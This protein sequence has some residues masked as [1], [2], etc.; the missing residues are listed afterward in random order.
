MI[1]L[2]MI[3][4]SI[5]QCPIQW[6]WSHSILLCTTISPPVPTHKNFSHQPWRWTMPVNEFLPQYPDKGWITVTVL[7]EEQMFST[8]PSIFWSKCNQTLESQWL[9]RLLVRWPLHSHQGHEEGEG[10]AG[11]AEG[12]HGEPEDGAGELWHWLGCHQ[13]VYLCCFLPPGCQVE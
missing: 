1:T 10:S 13:K 6:T 7:F 3:K 11:P 5:I 8:N 12:D 9:L 4:A 2:S